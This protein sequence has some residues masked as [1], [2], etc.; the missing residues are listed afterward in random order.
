[1]KKSLYID[2]LGYLSRAR[3]RWTFL[4]KRKQKDRG[5]HRGRRPDNLPP[6][7]QQRSMVH[8]EGRKSR[9]SRADYEY[10]LSA[11]QTTAQP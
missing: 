1:M 9:G 10:A 11:G 4:P 6:S 3:A 8:A 5:H 7:H 2:G